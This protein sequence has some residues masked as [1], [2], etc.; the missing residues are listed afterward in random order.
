MKRTTSHYQIRHSGS[1]RFSAGG[2]RSHFTKRGKIWRSEGALKRHLEFT[3]TDYTDCEVVQICVVQFEG[4][5]SPVQDWLNELAASKAQKRREK[6][7][8]KAA[9]E[10]A[11]SRVLA[12]KLIARFG[13]D[14]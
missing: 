3:D 11:N 5:R 7:E 13:V 14:P 9:A 4:K 10:E 8:K 12:R 2:R 1:G 6:E